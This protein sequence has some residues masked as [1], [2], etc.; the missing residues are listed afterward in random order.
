MKKTPLH[1]IK[2]LDFYII[3][4]G[5]VQPE[6]PEQAGLESAGALDDRTFNNLKNKGILD[7][8]YAFYSDFRLDTGSIQQIL[9]YIFRNHLQADH[10]VIKLLP[11]LET[12]EQNR[13]G[14]VSYG[15]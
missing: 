13:N 6:D 7:K 12:A 10:D 14:L 2:M 5:Q 3:K 9:Q 4:D 15:H 8:Q 1:K 11:L